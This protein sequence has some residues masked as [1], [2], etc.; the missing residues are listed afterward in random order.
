MNFESHRPRQPGILEAKRAGNPK[1]SARISVCKKLTSL[2]ANRFRQSD[3]IM[4]M[5]SQLQYRLLITATV[6]FDRVL[7][8]RSFFWLLISAAGIEH[9]YLLATMKKH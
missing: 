7:S 4:E 6:L 8:M 3:V 1:L 9:L 2:T 5:D